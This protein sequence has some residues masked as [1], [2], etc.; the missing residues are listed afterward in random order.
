MAVALVYGS[1]LRKDSGKVISNSGIIALASTLIAV[2]AG[3]II[4]PSVFAFGLDPALGTGLTFVTMPNVFH[5]MPA[6]TVFGTLFYL[7]FFLAALTSFIG[8]F[9]GIIAWVRDQFR[10]PRNTCVYIV[11]A[12]VLFVSALSA[13]SSKFFLLADYIANSLCIIFGALLMSLFVGWVWKIEN[14]GR[15]AGLESK[16]LL[17]IWAVL[18]KYVA[19]AVILV[20]W[21]NEL[22][23]VDRAIRLFTGG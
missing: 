11:G 6:G 20:T 15:A 7:L 12:G 3:L 9:E 2:M 22:K 23:L 8:A 5:Q 14:F 1:Y 4:F 21:M 10:L 13:Y 17:A 19:P 18:I 16:G